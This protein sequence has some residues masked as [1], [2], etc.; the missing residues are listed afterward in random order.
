MNIKQLAYRIE[1]DDAF[2]DKVGK[3]LAAELRLKRKRDNG[4]YDLASGDKTDQGLARTVLRT[5]E[6]QGEAQS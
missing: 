1:A 3:A 5:I 2:A 6:D 4:R